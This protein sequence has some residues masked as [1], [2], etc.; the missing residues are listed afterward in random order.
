MYWG[1]IYGRQIGECHESGNR[2]LPDVTEQQSKGHESREPHQ[3]A[4]GRGSGTCT[5]EDGA[6]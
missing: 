6:V 3:E 2:A 4:D 1:Q 5:G